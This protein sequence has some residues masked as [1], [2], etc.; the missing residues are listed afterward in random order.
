MVLQ[1]TCHFAIKRVWLR[2]FYTKT[3]RWE[4]LE[5]TCAAPTKDLVWNLLY[6]IKIGWC[7]RRHATSP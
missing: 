4:L 6:I 1:E 7:C 3:T 5:V 2:N